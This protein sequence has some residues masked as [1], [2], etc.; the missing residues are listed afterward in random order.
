MKFDFGAGASG[1]SGAAS[2]ILGGQEKAAGLGIEA[3]ATRLKAHGD[4]VEAQNYDL[5]ST[6]ANQNDEFTKVSTAIKQT[7]M[8]RQIYLGLGATS[9]DVGGAG[10]AASG[11]ALDIMRSSAQQGALT[12]QVLG[13]QGLITEAGYQ[14]QATAYTNLSGAA[15]YAAGIENDMADKQDALASKTQSDSLISGGVKA[16]VGIASMFL[17]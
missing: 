3:E 5:A 10:F 7:Q 1:I 14:E 2:D 8:Q 6:L 17:L 4:L 11:S 15:R 9:A 16:A 12:K 13:E